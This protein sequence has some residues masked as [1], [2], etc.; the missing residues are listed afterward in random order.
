MV[1]VCQI[2]IGVISEQIA[3]C[4]DTVRSFAENNGYGYEL[5]TELSDKSRGKTNIRNLCDFEKINILSTKPNSLVID[6]DVL[7]NIDAVF[8]LSDT[9]KINPQ[10]DFFLYNGNDTKTFIILKNSIEKSFVSENEIGMLN[11]AWNRCIANKQISL[12]SSNFVLNGYK[13][14]HWNIINKIGGKI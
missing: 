3:E 8:N 13:H 12:S 2:A 7:I 4:M 9:I 10:G 1:T 11:K 6:W 5:I 14:L